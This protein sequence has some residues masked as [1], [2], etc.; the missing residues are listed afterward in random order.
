M[1]LDENICRVLGT[2]SRPDL[3]IEL[4]FCGLT[5]AGTSALEETLGRNQG[6]TKLH[7]CKIDYSVLANGLRG[8]SRLKSL[9]VE[10][11]SSPV[12]A[13]QD[14]LGIAG[15]LKDNKGLVDFNLWQP[16][17]MSDETWDAICDSLT[18]HPTFEVLS[19]RPVQRHPL[20]PAVLN[21]RI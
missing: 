19:I 5:N 16:L 7:S 15:S 3:E 14:I 18:T 10:S 8:N 2:F 20:S 4:K 6:P 17:P 13:H 11:S 1:F 12:V 9:S 21:S